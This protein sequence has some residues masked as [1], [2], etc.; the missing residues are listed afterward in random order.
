VPKRV[1][2]VLM[3]DRVQLWKQLAQV[4]LH[5]EIALDRLARAERDP[6]REHGMLLVARRGGGGGGDVARAYPTQAEEWEL[7]A[8]TAEEL[9]A[10]LAAIAC[11]LRVITSR[12]Q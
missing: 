2:L 8:Q 9:D 12:P 6:R 4:K 5:G 10:W 3:P 7:Q 11:N 1:H